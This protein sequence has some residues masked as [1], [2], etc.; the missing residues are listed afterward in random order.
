MDKLDRLGWEAGIAF[1]AY[2]LR[3]GI[4]VNQAQVLDRI[5]RL[6][7]PGWKP[8][9]SPRVRRLY[10][11]VIGGHG[12]RPGV[13]RYHL[14]Y[15]DGLRY[16]RTM[17]LDGLF[18]LLESDVHAFVAEEAR[19]R[20]FVHAGVVGWQGKAIVIPG[21]S[22]SGKSTLTAALVR[23]GATYY[24][25]EFAVFDARGR[26]HP[27]PRPLAIRHPVDTIQTRYPVEALGGT[28]GVKPLPVGLVVASQF[29]AG[30]RWRPRLLTP[31]QAMMTLL[32]HTI[33]L[34][35]Q[36]HLSLATLQQA[37]CQVPVLQG[38]RGEAGDIVDKIL[39]TLDGCR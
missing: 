15:L 17:D 29:R 9:K 18:A 10:S 36:P 38:T 28:S 7:P 33:A 37:V 1:V 12:P 34:R 13:R 16:R 14:L 32:P 31:G 5:M 22:F 20:V 39:H 11:V 2:G 3:I 27:F 26:V 21:R 25:D 6:L 30:A 35:R 4:R 23:A 24:S 19:R 8:A